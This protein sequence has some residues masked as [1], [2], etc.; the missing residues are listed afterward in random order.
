MRKIDRIA[1]EIDLI[2][3]AL[4]EIESDGDRYG[5]DARNHPRYG[6]LR[7]C[8]SNLIEII[9]FRADLFGGA[10][11]LLAATAII[12]IIA[13]YT[14]ATIGDDA[15]TNLTIVACLALG[16]GTYW[17]GK[18]HRAAVLR[19]RYREWVTPPS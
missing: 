16:G 5:A 9:E 13:I 14:P 11:A 2:A 1:F 10:L 17:L 3:R 7:R 6:H 18:K 4:Q 15:R 8:Q 12:S 19:D